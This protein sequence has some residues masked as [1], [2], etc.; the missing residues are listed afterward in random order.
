MNG[1][2][3]PG[4]SSTFCPLDGRGIFARLLVKSTS[5]KRAG[6][7]PLAGN[8]ARCIPG[9]SLKVCP[10]RPGIVRS[11]CAGSE[12]MTLRVVDPAWLPEPG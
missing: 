9:F 4:G 1:S 12:I 7:A 2:V 11:I 6:E 10:P 5:I 8:A 3:G